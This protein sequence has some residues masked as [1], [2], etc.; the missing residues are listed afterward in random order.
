M[1]RITVRTEASSEAERAVYESYVGA[2]N[3]VCQ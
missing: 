1:W 2:D 3:S